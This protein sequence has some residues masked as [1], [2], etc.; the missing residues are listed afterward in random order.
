VDSDGGEGDEIEPDTEFVEGLIDDSYIDDHNNTSIQAR[1]LKSIRSPSARQNG[2]FK[3]PDR[4]RLPPIT[5]NI[6]SQPVQPDVSSYKEI[7]DSFVVDEDDVEAAASSSMDELEHAEL[8][9]KRR[10]RNQKKR[11]QRILRQS[12][13]SSSDDDD[14]DDELQM[15]LKKSKVDF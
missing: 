11:K 6:F 4:P 12:N 9:L 13:E 8:I 1:Y 14:N 10:R 2:G 7:D 5:A 15:A 3:I